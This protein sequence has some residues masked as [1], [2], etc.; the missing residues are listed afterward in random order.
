MAIIWTIADPIHWCI[1]VAIG[2][3]ELICQIC[4]AYN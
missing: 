1:Y 2:E 4:N 3:M